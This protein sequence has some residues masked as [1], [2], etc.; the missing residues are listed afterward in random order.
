MEIVE[1]RG[2]HSGGGVYH[3][4]G[5]VACVNSVCR[6]ACVGRSGAVGRSIPCENRPIETVV[7]EYGNLAAPICKACEIPVGVISI[8]C[9]VTQGVSPRLEPIQVVIAERG[10]IRSV[11]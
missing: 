11:P 10:G 9:S 2:D 8:S 7:L 6:S 1:R 3:A 5:T 4:R